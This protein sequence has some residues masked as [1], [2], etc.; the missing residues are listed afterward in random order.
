MRDELS[1]RQAAIRIRLAGDKVETICQTLHRTPQGSTNGD[2]GI[3]NL[4]QPDEK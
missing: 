4:A 3:W 2:G 1:A